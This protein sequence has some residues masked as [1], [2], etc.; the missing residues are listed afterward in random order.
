MDEA[1]QPGLRRAC[2]ARVLSFAGKARI[3]GCR[4]REEH[5][6][7]RSAQA[8]AIREERDP[9]FWEAVA[10]CPEV[11]RA[12]VLEAAHSLADIV[13][14]PWV[15][16][17]AATHGGYLFCRLDGVGHVW[18][19]HSMFTA[20]GHGREAMFAAVAAFDRMFAGPM[21][22]LTTYEVAVN[23]RSRPPARFGFV[24]AGGFQGPHGLKSWVLTRD[25]WMRSPG[26]ERLS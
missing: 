7:A 15:T 3:P 11:A 17:L 16:P 13:A 25:A 26:R 21:Q 22:V 24:P 14:H 2:A 1:C 18:E 10:A 8:V 6:M 19:L 4:S 23:P 20:R 5:V 12:A 9:A